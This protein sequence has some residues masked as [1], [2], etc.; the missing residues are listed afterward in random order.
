MYRVYRECIKEKD[1]SIRGKPYRVRIITICIEC[2][3]L[4]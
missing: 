2:I 1:Y 3:E 4:F